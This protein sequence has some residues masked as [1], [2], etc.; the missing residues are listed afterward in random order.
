MK[1]AINQRI[2]DIRLSFSCNVEDDYKQQ[3][4]LEI[5]IDGI[6]LSAKADIIGW[7]YDRLLKQFEELAFKIAFQTVAFFFTKEEGDELIKIVRNVAKSWLD[8]MKN[9]LD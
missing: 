2:T 8:N 9:I 3:I 7:F 6:T 1:R 5:D 4:C